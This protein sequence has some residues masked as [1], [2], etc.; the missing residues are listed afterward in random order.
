MPGILRL[1]TGSILA[2]L[3]AAFSVFAADS[4]S[5]SNRSPA[6]LMSLN[7]EIPR[8]SV[9][10]SLRIEPAPEKNRYK[11]SYVK[12]NRRRDLKKTDVVMIGPETLNKLEEIWGG[13]GFP[14]T[15]ITSSGSCNSLPEA[16]QVV[17][18]R[19]SRVVCQRGKARNRLMR[20][21]DAVSVLFIRPPDR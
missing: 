19:G 7:L 6:S 20:F 1:V 21:R 12:E 18:P 3:F 4:T 9:S 8:W 2:G 10:M 17:T 16:W 11:V 15:D 5:P 14:L 13:T